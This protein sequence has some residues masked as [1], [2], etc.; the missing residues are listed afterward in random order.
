[1]YYAFKAAMIWLILVAHSVAVAE[2]GVGIAVKAAT[3]VLFFTALVSNILTNTFLSV[4]FPMKRALISFFNASI[5]F[6]P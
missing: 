6:R 1:M 2:A 3:S 4:L 5:S